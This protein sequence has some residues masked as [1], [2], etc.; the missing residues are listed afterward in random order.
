MNKLRQ[1]YLHNPPHAYGDCF[2]TALAC[3]LD[4]RSPEEVPH[5]YAGV[6]HD[7]QAAIDEAQDDFDAWL[8]RR[9][10]LGLTW[11]TADVGDVSDMDAWLRHV[12][13]LYPDWQHVLV[14]GRGEFGV[15]HV[16]IVRA[17]RFVWDP[18]TGDRMS[19]VGPDVGA[20]GSEMMWSS[21][22][23]VHRP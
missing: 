4:C 5:F 22:E 8:R 14:G 20:D 21:A 17:G 7:D 23:L 3:L 2:R 9:H 16:V 15:N 18:R 10:R 6:G 13:E 1:L 12:G 11:R 19:L